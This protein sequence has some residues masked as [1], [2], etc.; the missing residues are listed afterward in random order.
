MNVYYEKVSFL[1]ISL[2]DIQ[3]ASEENRNYIDLYFLTEFR[4]GSLKEFS[5]FLPL[6]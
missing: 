6:I 4:N 3:F 1:K 5:P 2:S